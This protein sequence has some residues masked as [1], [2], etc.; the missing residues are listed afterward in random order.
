MGGGGGVSV[1]AGHA[2]AKER[3][4][5]QTGTDDTWITDVHENNVCVLYK[6]VCVLSRQQQRLH[7]FAQG[8]LQKV[9]LHLKIT[10]GA[11]AVNHF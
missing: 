1:T 9:A 2:A 5:L 3:G 11:E 10:H 4:R 8:R 7:V 6:L